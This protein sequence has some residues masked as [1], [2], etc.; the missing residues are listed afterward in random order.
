MSLPDLNLLVA[1][2]VLLD[3][4]SVAGAARRMHL[5]APAMSRTL[6]R[7]GPSTRRSTIWGFHAGWG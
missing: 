1:L 4:G 6:A 5:S 7:V 3:E 2:D